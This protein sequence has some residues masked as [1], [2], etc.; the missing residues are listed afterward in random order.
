MLRGRVSLVFGIGSV[1]PQES[2]ETRATERDAEG[3][4]DVE[5]FRNGQ[6]A[7]GALVY[8]S[9]FFIETSRGW[10]LGSCLARGPLATA[11]RRG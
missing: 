9:L 8:P 7:S 6:G 11:L 10:V 3:C 5:M 2:R 4:E 1:R